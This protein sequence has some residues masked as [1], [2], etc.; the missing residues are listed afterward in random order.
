MRFLLDRA[1]VGLAACTAALLLTATPPA[2][3]G[4]DFVLAQAITTNL[5][6]TKGRTS[7]RIFDPSRAPRGHGP[8]AFTWFWTEVSPART[9][10]D[11]Q[12]WSRVVGIIESARLK[13]KP[14]FGS[15]SAVEGILANYGDILQREAQRRNV[16]VPLLIAVIAVESGGNPRA[17]SP[18]GAG[19][20]MQLMPGTARRFGV[21]NSLAPAQN[22]RGGAHYLD[23][24]L[25]FFGDDAVLAL[26]GYNAGEQ[27]VETHLGVPPFSETR[28][29]VAKVAGAYWVARQFCQTPPKG[30]REACALK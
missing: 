5:A 24:L 29:Y 8:Q 3:A 11:A 18:K 28:D 7:K 9:A 15:R 27:A 19:G 12:R 1:T 26:A 13:G 6:P 25:R 16:S 2:M 10:A 17:I 22:I 30:P 14:V 20:L 23:W 4:E 21:S